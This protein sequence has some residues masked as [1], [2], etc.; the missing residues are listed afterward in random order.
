MARS[1]LFLKAFS[2]IVLAVLAFTG[3][4]YLSFVP[5]VRGTV[6]Q[7]EEHTGRLVLDNIYEMAQNE[8]RHLQAWRESAMDAHREKLRHIIQ[9]AVAA[10][11]QIEK[12]AKAN[13]LSPKATRERILEAVRHLTYGDEDDYVFIADYNARLTSHPDP[14]LHGADFSDVRDTRGNLIVPPMVK[15]AR[16]EGEGFHHY[17]WRRLGEDEPSEKLSY[18]KH[19][20]ERDWV[21]GTGVYIDEVEAE[22]Q[23]RK[24]ALAE[25]LRQHLNDTR[26]AQTGYLYIFD[27]DMN[28]IIHPN[29]NIEG[30]NFS[31]MENPA[32]GRPIGK[33]LMQAA[34]SQSGKLVYKWDRPSDPGNYVYDK[35]AWVRYLPEFDWYIAS[36]V[37]LSEFRDTAN[38]LTLRIISVAALVLITAV[39]GAYF[40]L[41]RLTEPISRLAETA[42]R[43]GQG[44][45]DAKT[46]IQ[47]DDEIGVLATAFNSMVDRLKD[48]INNMESRVAERTEELRRSVNDL[49][50]RNRESAEIN[51]MGEL[52]QS[53]HTEEEVFTVAARTCQALFP[54]DSGSTYM[55]DENDGLTLVTEWGTAAPLRSMEDSHT[56]W[57]VR[58][59][60][61]QR[62]VADC[63][64]SLCPQCCQPGTASLC[65]PL[66]AEGTVSGVIKINAPATEADADASLTQRE[67]LL[68][69]VA[70]QVALTVT[71]LRLRDRLR[72]QSIRDPLTGL[73]N[74]RRL[75]EALEKELA[76]A[77]RHDE[78]VAVLMLDVDNFKECNDT[79]GH[80]VGDAVLR[81]LGA[82]LSRSLRRED[83]A[84]RYGGEEFAL[85]IP[86]TDEMALRHVAELVRSRVEEQ[87]ATALGA[88]VEGPITVSIGGASFPDHGRDPQALLT[89]ADEALYR[90]KSDGRN[91]VVCAAER[92]MAE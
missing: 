42:S 78:Q 90:A 18:Y 86:K 45:L 47:R 43:V 54:E 23:A 17:W 16:E 50:R 40:F 84:Y 71:N 44:D 65:V 60:Q 39:A 74:R 24:A 30:T 53:C 46:D 76:R 34:E 25:R 3:A 80:E 11:D 73:F 33:E 87:V 31:D 66:V 32:T 72:Q 6:Q 51:R 20:P 61:S 75:E 81:E 62:D 19:L 37:Y 7:Q 82:L 4:S 35:I 48:Q 56:C 85:I 67:P 14:D 69:T 21:I 29:P 55:V 52:L 79:Y 91:R 12:E 68:T 70:E 92:Q 27:S 59:G 83:S 58:R 63:Q 77:A 89:A 9:V 88:G 64:T 28:M 36:S 49:E 13:G 5:W 8:H 10:I 41:R 1:Q 22:V 26:I 38:A 57:A 15:G 2:T